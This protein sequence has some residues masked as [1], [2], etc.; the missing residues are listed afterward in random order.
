[1]LPGPHHSPS[2]IPRP[3]FFAVV[4]VL[5]LGA[6]TALATM[7]MRLDLRQIVAAADRAFV[8]RVVSVHAD[9]DPSGL[10]STWVSFAV[11]QVIKGKIGSGLTMK[12][13]G[14]TT[15]LDDGSMLHLPGLPTYAPGEEMVIFLS[16]ESE[17]GFCSPIGLAQGKFPIVR[18]A[19]RAM[20]ATTAE[21]LG[22]LQSMRR[23]QASG[24]SVAGEIALNDF[25]DDVARLVT[26]PAHQ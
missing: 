25:L 5:A 6:T 15:P 26:D 21:N 20:V 8:G 3:A 9:R 23:R 10:P 11:D 16:G 12:Q 1:M 14:T 2:R 24:A 4:S 7:T 17:A 13:L 18:R 22:V 19:G